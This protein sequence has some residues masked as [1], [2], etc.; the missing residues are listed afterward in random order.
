MKGRG[1]VFRLRRKGV[2]QGNE[3]GRR[4]CFSS[5]DKGKS[6]PERIYLDF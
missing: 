2:K 3:V 5:E 6:H 4:V 1:K